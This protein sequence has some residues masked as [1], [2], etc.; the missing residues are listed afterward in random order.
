MSRPQAQKSAP[1]RQKNR[2]TEDQ[3]RILEASFNQEK[4]LEP[5]RKFQLSYQLGMPA[6]QVAIWYQNKRARWKNQ[7]IEF[8]Y[9]TVQIR[10]DSAL[11]EKGRLQREVIR[12][13]EE[14]QKA[15]ETITS[16]NHS[17]PS[18]SSLSTSCDEDGSSSLPN[19]MNNHWQNSQGLQVEDLYAC[20]MGTGDQT[21]FVSNNYSLFK[22]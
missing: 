17:G 5:E 19:H 7:N 12:L 14:L 6:K 11:A 8:D 1:K 10:L 15:N 3:L 16:L 20:L 9:R 4:K 21:S 18:I 13:R 2:L 22:P